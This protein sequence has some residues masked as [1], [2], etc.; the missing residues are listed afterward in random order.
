LKH[1]SHHEVKDAHQFTSIH[2]KPIEN[3]MKSKEYVPSDKDRHMQT[4]ATD[5]PSIKQTNSVHAKVKKSHMRTSMFTFHVF[6]WG[7]G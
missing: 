6:A 2:L 4:H 5:G 7:W 3:F 1:R